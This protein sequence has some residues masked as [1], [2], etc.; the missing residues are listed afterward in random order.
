MEITAKEL[1]EKVNNGEK[2]IVDFYGTWCGP[3]RILKPIFEKVSYEN[4]TEVQLYMM[5]VDINKDIVKSLGIKSVP[6]IK[7]FNK[8]EVVDT[9]IGI[10]QEG[11]IKGL[12]NDLLLN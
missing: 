12:V 9:K 7:V 3:C 4:T 8:G 2:I 1:E 11:M 5:D 10:I 6:T